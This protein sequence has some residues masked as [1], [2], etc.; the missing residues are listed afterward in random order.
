MLRLFPPSQTNKQVESKY[1]NQQNA[2]VAVRRAN[3]AGIRHSPDAGG[4][5]SRYGE[6]H[7]HLDNEPGELLVA[8]SGA[9]QPQQTGNAM[10]QKKRNSPVALVRF[11]Q[12][13]AT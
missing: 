11:V 10:G 3:F 8:T 13:F 6:R 5:S 9:D 12:S 7:L 1:P 2:L 4:P